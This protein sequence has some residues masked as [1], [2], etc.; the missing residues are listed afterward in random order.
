M[1]KMR[2]LRLL[3]ELTLDE[4]YLRTGR[5]L[6]QPRLSRIERGIAIPSKE[7]KDL[8]SRALQEPVKKIFPEA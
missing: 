4:L 8:I 6:S 2:R 3:K 5:K 7:E 1:R